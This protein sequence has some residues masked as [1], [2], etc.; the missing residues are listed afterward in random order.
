M[1]N[2]IML[3]TIFKI[4]HPLQIRILTYLYNDL[5]LGSAMCKIFYII[6]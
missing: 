2:L 4:H 3:A 5:Q 6:Q 1:W